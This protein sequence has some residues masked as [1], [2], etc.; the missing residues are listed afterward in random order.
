MTKMRLLR[1]SVM[2][3][4]AEM[5]EAVAVGVEADPLLKAIAGVVAAVVCRVPSG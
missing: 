2:V 3:V 1:V 4:T 5:K